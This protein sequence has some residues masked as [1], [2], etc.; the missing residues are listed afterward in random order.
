MSL[1]FLELQKTWFDLWFRIFQG[2]SCQGRICRQ[3]GHGGRHLRDATSQ[4]L[5]GQ[6]GGRGR[7]IASRGW[8]MG[9]IH[10]GIVGHRD[11]GNRLQRR[12]P[13]VLLVVS[14]RR[15]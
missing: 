4:L 10:G 2:G 1:L 14:E 5:P 13:T 11:W 8:E 3:V 12:L 6:E 9:N 7:A 15:L